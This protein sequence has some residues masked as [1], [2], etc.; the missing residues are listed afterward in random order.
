MTGPK[1]TRLLHRIG[2]RGAALLFFAL[3]DLVFAKS[4]A[5][6]PPSTRSSPTYAFMA[7]VLPLW[8]WAALWGVVGLMCLVQAFMANDLPAFVASSAMNVGWA[9]VHLAGFFVGEVPRGYVSAV[10]WLGYAG[11]VQ[12]IA[13]WAE[14]VRR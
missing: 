3:V 9:C 2:H 7:T 1:L 5:D 8:G 4:L 11:F 13:S 10:I 6:A 12:V 14:P